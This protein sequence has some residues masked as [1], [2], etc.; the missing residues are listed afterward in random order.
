MSNGA[1]CAIIAIAKVVLFGAAGL[2]GVSLVETALSEG[3]QVTAFIRNT[4]LPD[5]LTDKVRNVVNGIP[6]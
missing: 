5:H 3:Y 4:P 6:K 2:V 1:D